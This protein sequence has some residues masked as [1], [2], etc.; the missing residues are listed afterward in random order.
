MAKKT[1]PK[2]KVKK[3]SVN[4]LAIGCA[5]VV[6]VLFITLHILISYLQKFL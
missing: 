3:K 5:I 6:I 1:L 4:G 2:V